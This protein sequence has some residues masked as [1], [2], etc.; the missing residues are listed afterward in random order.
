MAQKTDVTLDDEA[1]RKAL[2]RLSEA[3]TDTRPI[4]ASIGEHLINT[5]RDRFRTQTAP[6]GTPWAPISEGWKRRKKRNRGKILTWRG[7]LRGNI[8]YR[9]SADEVLVGS[10]AV[11]AATH[12]FGAKAGDFGATKNGAPIP[13]GTIPARPFLGLSTE[14]TEAISR[15]VIDALDDAAGP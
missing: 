6:D 9:A 1:L 5:T 2:K 10:P 4:M 15:I 7:I 12:Q 14:D 8:A 13:F 11:Y 3:T